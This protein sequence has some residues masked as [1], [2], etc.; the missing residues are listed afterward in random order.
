[1]PEV[2]TGRAPFPQKVPFR[3]QACGVRSFELSKLQT[4]CPRSKK[5]TAQPFHSGVPLQGL[6]FGQ[7]QRG[8]SRICQRLRSNPLPPTNAMGT[9][10]INLS[11]VL[12][13]P[14]VGGGK[15]RHSS[16]KS[17]WGCLSTS[18]KPGSPASWL[19]PRCQ[20]NESPLL[21]RSERLAPD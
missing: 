11:G 8:S 12:Q 21:L 13:I 4:S 1:M 5:S 17:S 3:T 18:S 14:S 15:G 6:I 9:R 19:K 2:P 16:N 20:F 7:K 10:G